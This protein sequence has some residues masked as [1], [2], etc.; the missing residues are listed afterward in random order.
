VVTPNATRRVRAP[1]LRRTS[2]PKDEELPR[3][4]PQDRLER[5][6]GF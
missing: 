3:L 1:A 2:V 4:R 6:L 5:D